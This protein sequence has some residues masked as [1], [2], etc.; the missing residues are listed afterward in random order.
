MLLGAVHCLAVSD[1]WLVSMSCRAR[2]CAAVQALCYWRDLWRQMGDLQMLEEPRVE[3]QRDFQLLQPSCLHQGLMWWCHLMPKLSCMWVGDDSIATSAFSSK[4]TNYKCICF[5]QH[6]EA[7]VS[8]ATAFLCQTVWEIEIRL[9]FFFSFCFRNKPVTFCLCYA[10]RR[11]VWQEGE[12]GNSATEYLPNHTL[13]IWP[14]S[15]VLANTT[16]HSPG[17]P[18][19]LLTL[20]SSLVDNNADHCSGHNEKTDPHSNLITWRWQLTIDF[21]HKPCLLCPTRSPALS[22]CVLT[23]CAPVTHKLRPPHPHP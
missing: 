8:T 6:T 18:F 4:K 21:F 7:L 13:L 20:S 11:C 2:C 15:H 5:R 1:T 17:F 12:G 16:S 22:L 10:G 14:R 9:V 3:P 19:C 23:L